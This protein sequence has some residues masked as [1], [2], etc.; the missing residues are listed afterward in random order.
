M[1][2][3]VEAFIPKFA[4]IPIYNALDIYAYEKAK[5]RR[6]GLMVD[7]FDILIG[8]TSIAN[9]MVMVSNNVRHM[10]RFDNIDLQDWT[11]SKPQ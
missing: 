3:V 10:S 1:R 7:D 4:A 11:K 9:Q 6:Q 5:L 8:S 2:P